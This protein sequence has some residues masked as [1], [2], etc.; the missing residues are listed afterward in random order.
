MRAADH[1]VRSLEAHGLE[2][3]YCVPGESYLAV[4]DA[5]HDSNRINTVVCRHESVMEAGLSSSS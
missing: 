2:R 5:L 3:L 1:I 4:L